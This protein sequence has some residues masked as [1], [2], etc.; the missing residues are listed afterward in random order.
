M[1]AWVAKATGRKV[2][3]GKFSAEVPALGI[4]SV[5]A[6][7]NGTAANGVFIE[8]RSDFEM[9]ISAVSFQQSHG[10]RISILWVTRPSRLS[11]GGEITI[12]SV[13]SIE[14]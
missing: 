2:S 9:F 10:F 1:F 6:I 3:L 13:G 8:T 7:I 11:G 14:N 4:P 5:K 12:A